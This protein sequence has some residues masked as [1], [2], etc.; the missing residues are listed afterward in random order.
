MDFVVDSIIEVL[1]EVVNIRSVAFI[2]RKHGLDGTN[3]LLRKSDVGHLGKIS[4]DS[5]GVGSWGAGLSLGGGSSH[6]SSFVQDLKT[7]PVVVTVDIGE[8]GSTESGDS[9]GPDVT[10]DLIVLGVEFA[11]FEGLDQFGGDGRGI[12]LLE[13]HLTVASLAVVDEKVVDD[14]HLALIVDHDV[15]GL[16]VTMGVVI[17][18]ENLED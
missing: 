3:E 8:S 18:L 11:V 16:D 1:V 5:V 2:V 10:L 13:N 9:D 4:V 12:A 15:F 7:S 6:F 17:V 14:L